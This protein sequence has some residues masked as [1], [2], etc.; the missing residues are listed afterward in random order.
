MLVGLAFPLHTLPPIPLPVWL[1]LHMMS[2][3]DVQYTLT[4]QFYYVVLKLYL[5]PGILYAG[6]FVIMYSNCNSLFI[7]TPA[8]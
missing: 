6:V 2:D 3:S 7:N 1:R 5:C 8:Y 4:Q